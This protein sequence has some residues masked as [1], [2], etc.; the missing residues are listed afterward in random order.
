MRIAWT[1]ERCRAV[2][3]RQ[4][5]LFKR[6]IY[7]TSQP[8]CRPADHRERRAGRT[9]GLRGGAE[10]GG[11]S[12]P[13]DQRRG[14]TSFGDDGRGDVYC[15]LAQ[16]ALLLGA[17]VLVVWLVDENEALPFQSQP[18]V[19]LDKA[20]VS[21]IV[22]TWNEEAVLPGLLQNL[23]QLCP[24]A[25]EILVA[26][27]G[28]S[29]RTVQIAEAA[30][31]KVVPSPKGRAAQMNFAAA[32]AKG[33]IL[34]FVHA[35]SHLPERAV[36]VVRKT[37]GW[38]RTVLGGFRTNIRTGEGRLLRFMTLHH[39]IK[40]HYC[41]AVVRPLDYLRGLRCLFGDQTLFCTAAAFHG[42]G[43]YS[44]ELP[45]MEDADL[46]LRLHLAGA[47]SQRPSSCKRRR[48]RIVQIWAPPAETSGRRL[49]AWGNLH[50]TFVHFRIALAWYWGASPEQ[51]VQL[52][53]RLYTDKYR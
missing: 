44:R 20:T 9:A 31:F 42:V 37:L 22:P 47:P 43:G 4:R 16:I 35:D 8:C 30:G 5:L 14:Y 51:L 27:G 21:I 53:N 6:T 45:I 10:S 52:Y 13:P 12:G 24:P 7:H 36:A 2:C 40:S 41:P 23:S 34:C 17:G 33:D 39:F 25:L 49:A 50:A 1:G 46:C 48:G 11:G 26:D 3:S 29:D 18:G 38:R 15:R 28:S 19:S 32:S